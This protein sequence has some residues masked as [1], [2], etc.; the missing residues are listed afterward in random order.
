M[1]YCLICNGEFTNLDK[2][3]EKYHKL[4]PREENNKG[5]KL[6]PLCK[7]IVGNLWKH[8]FSE[9]HRCNVLKN[10]VELE[11]T[12]EGYIKHY[13]NILKTTKEQ[14]EN[15]EEHPF[16]QSAKE[17]LDYINYNRLREYIYGGTTRKRSTRR[18]NSKHRRPGR[19][20]RRIK[21]NHKKIH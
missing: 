1:R 3:L 15:D 19:P 11:Y 13:D 10:S 14:V 9:L 7:V 17:E 8:Y 5:N 18:R 12:A 20:V 16:W 4:T 2:H 21:T 6:C